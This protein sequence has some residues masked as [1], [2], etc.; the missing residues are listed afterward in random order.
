M[1]VAACENALSLSV[2]LAEELHVFVKYACHV[3]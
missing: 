3:Y 2:E 1:P